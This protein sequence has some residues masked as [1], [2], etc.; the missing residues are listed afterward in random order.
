MRFRRKDAQTLPIGLSDKASSIWVLVV[1]SSHTGIAKGARLD[2]ALCNLDWRNC[3]P[4]ATVTHLPRLSSDHT[5][6][7]LRTAG[8]VNARRLST[9]K[10]QAAWF[11]H[12]GLVQVVQKSW[13]QNHQFMMNVPRLTA[14]LE[15][16]N[17]FTFGNINY[18]KRL[19]LARLEGVQTRLAIS[20]HG[21]LAKLEKKL[22]NEYQEILYQEELLWFQR[23]RE[24]WITS[25]DRN[26]P[27]YHAA[28]TVRKA[29]NT[30]TSLQRPI[31]PG[32]GS[33]MRRI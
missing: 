19:V 10:F 33:H 28:A 26:T 1:Q 14:A 9:F 5:P 27:Y 29:R 11:T 7:L 31:R 8:R 22:G 23:S 2:R 12:E 21:G 4:G 17:K 20:Y 13:D 15:N 25:G 6:I 30:I 24:E 3:F 18:R 32:F 16:W